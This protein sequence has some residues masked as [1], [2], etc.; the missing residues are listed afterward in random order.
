MSTGYQIKDQY[1]PGLPQV[2]EYQHYYPFG[3]QLEALG[4]TSGN[5]LK[6]NYLYNGK[7]LQEDYGLNWYDYGAR[8]YDPVI[9]RWSTVDPLAEKGRRWSPYNYALNNPIRFID[10]DGMWI[11]NYDIYENGTIKVERTSD[12]TNTYTYHKVDG[13][14]VDLGIY[15]VTKSNGRDLV[16][17]PNNGKSYNK[18]LSNNAN[19]LPEDGAAAFLGATY[20][21]YEKTAYKAKVNQFMTIDRKHSPD[22]DPKQHDKTLI[23][24]QYVAKDG[25]PYSTQAD[26]RQSTADVD[27]SN[28]LAQTFRNFGFNNEGKYNV[29]SQN[30]KGDGPFLKNSASCY[31]HQN[32]IHFQSLIKIMEIVG[33]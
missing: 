10:P 26:T 18:V 20:N 9:G 25:I 22:H 32:H 24:V 7:E 6:N 11:D 31:P 3:M 17:L 30:A 23:D 29:F 1:A 21:Y 15:D 2:M 28:T 12:K 33:K 4:Y 27:K 8:M 14:E 19:Y 13:S 16:E 5:D